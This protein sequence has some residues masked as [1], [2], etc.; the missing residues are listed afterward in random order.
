MAKRRGGVCKVQRIKRQGMRRICRDKR[1]RI[2]SNKP[3]RR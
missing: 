1:G 3:A 2:I